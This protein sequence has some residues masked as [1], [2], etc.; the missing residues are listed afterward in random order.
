[1]G[2]HHEED[3]HTLDPIHVFQ[4]AGGYLLF[5]HGR[6]SRFDYQYTTKS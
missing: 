3:A 2:V 5:F 6:T 4:S 1:M